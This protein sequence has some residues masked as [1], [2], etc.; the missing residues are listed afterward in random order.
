MGLI[1]QLGIVLCLLAIG[2][3][4]GSYF[5]GRH[6]KRLQRREATHQGFIVSQIKSFPGAIASGQPPQAFFA[7]AVISSDYLKTFLSNI[8]KFFGGE[9]KSYHSLLERARREALMRI[10]E[11]ASA[12]GYDTACNLRYETADIGGATNPRRGVVTVAVIASATA[13]C[14]KPSV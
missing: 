11:Q 2:F 6:F 12:A 9:M 7:E 1:I 14:R 3:F 4:A 8:R 10:I 13:Y 5:E